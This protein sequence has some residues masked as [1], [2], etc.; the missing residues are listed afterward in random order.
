M[1]FAH[2][3]YLWMLLGVPILALLLFAAY[4]ARRAASLEFRPA[5]FRA[6][7]GRNSGKASSAIAEIAYN[8]GLLVAVTMLIVATAQPY[9]NDKPIAV[10]EGPVQ[11]VFVVDVSR[12]MAA[13]D[14]RHNM[15]TDAGPVPDLNS[16]WG[17]RL[18]MAKYQMGK[19]MDAIAG[20]EVGLVTYTG[21]GFAQGVLSKDF[22]AL[23]FVL[24]HWVDIGTAPGDGSNYAKGIEMALDLLKQAD[25]SGKGKQQVIVLLT[26]GGY[27]GDQAGIAKTV[28]RLKSENVKL[29]IVGI[30]MP[31]ENAIPLYVDGARKGEMVVDGKVLTTSYEEDAIRNLK[32]MT[33]ATYKHIEL[34]A[35]SQ[36]VQVDWMTEISGS[37]VVFERR[38]LDR[39]LAG[40]AYA[41]ICLLVS[42][43]F[44][45]R[46]RPFRSNSK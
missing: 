26:D 37:K 24:K 11:A 20:N 41:L 3:E 27:T 28:E 44:L 38:L 32:A 6:R 12:S 34:D 18:Q 25:N 39:Y 14:Y 19:I 45:S 2:Q 5:R 13:E 30:G 31:G 1:G 42:T 7:D 16:P 8:G 35:Q 33:S 36:V 17:N 29:V 10:P 43:G 23:R 21:Q 15:P 40:A 22:A 4:R 46:R 9:Q